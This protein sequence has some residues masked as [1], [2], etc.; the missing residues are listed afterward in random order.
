[1]KKFKNNRAFT[2]LEMLIVLFV[3]SILMLLI[4]PNLSQKREVI[5]A[6]GTQALANVVQTQAALFALENKGEGVSLE[7][8]RARGYLSDQ[9][10]SQAIERNISLSGDGT[11]SYPK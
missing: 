7:V 10:V 8:L 2:L 11:V 9:Q 5:D 6:Q 1:M 4:V 3:V